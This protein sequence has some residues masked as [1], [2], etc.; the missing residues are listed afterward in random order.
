MKIT[1]KNMH[2]NN[3]DNNKQTI[4][5]EDNT[6]NQKNT[7]IHIFYSMSSYVDFIIY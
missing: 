3:Q 1:I 5:R 6:K 4:K 7:F 2:R